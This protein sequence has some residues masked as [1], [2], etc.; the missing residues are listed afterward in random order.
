MKTK[1]HMRPI[2][3]AV[4]TGAGRGRTAAGFLMRLC[5]SCYTGQQIY[6]TL[7]IIPS[8]I[9]PIGAEIDRSALT[10]RPVSDLLMTARYFP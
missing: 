3:S 6:L 1:K 4:S 7:S 5:A 10:A 9:F 2:K 8:M